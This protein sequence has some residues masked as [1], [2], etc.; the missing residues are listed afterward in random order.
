MKKEKREKKNKKTLPILTTGQL[1]LHSCLHFLGLHLSELTMAIRVNLSD[2]LHERK[3][4]RKEKKKKKEKN[5][6][7]KNFRSTAIN[8]LRN[9]H[10]EIPIQQASSKLFHNFN[11]VFTYSQLHCIA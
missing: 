7:R 8:P 6:L 10:H 4:K 11:R 1:F 3:R 2:I 5:P 9:S